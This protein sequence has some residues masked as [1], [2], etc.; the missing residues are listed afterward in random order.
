MKI[1][2]TDD[3]HP[4]LLEGLRLKGHIVD[5]QPDISLDQAKMIVRD[6]EG[7]VVNT[8]M[9]VDLAFLET[10][11]RLECIARLGSGMDTIDTQL[12]SE[13]IIHFFNTPEANSHAV[14]EHCLGLIL[15]LLRSIP[16]AHAEVQKRQWIREENRGTELASLKIGFIGFGH[17][18]KETAKLLQP[19]N[20]QIKVFDPY[21]EIG[22]EYFYVQQVGQLGDLMDCDLISL[23]VN[24]H[25]ETRHLINKTFIDSMNQAFYLINTSRGAIIQTKH[26]LEG[27]LDGKI[28]GAALDVLE[29]E[30][31][32][33]Y[34]SEELAIYDKLFQLPNVIVTPHIAGWTYE[35][36]RR[37][38]EA[39]LS[40]WPD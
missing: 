3:V 12:L 32:A 5:Y 38:A 21:V 8:K 37:I 33:D 11:L 10:A 27:L 25:E 22:P 4:V 39:V 16:K 34:H 28:I 26:L 29:N 9:K 6:Y 35:S 23:H 15:G 2:I 19:F 31:P 14:A 18:G 30:R 1:L 7:L 24:L 17:T 20:N 13:R 40:K 36:K